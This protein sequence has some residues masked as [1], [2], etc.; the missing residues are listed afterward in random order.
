VP[1]DEAMV[2]T[3]L[4]AYEEAG[5]RVV[6]AIATR[7]RAA[8]DVAPFMSTNLPEAVRKR[9]WDSDRKAKDELDLLLRKSGRSICSKES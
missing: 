8:L 5:I 4:S 2:D 6:F 1:Q 7:D 9:V 3:V